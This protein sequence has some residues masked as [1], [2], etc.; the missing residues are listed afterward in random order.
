[1]QILIKPII[2]KL[3]AIHCVS[4]YSIEEHA[5]FID[6]IRHWQDLFID[7]QTL[8]LG[9]EKVDRCL[10]FISRLPAYFSP[11]PQLGAFLDIIVSTSIDSSLPQ[12]IWD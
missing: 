9:L 12:L 1:M 3:S 10:Y 11:D 5:L 8:R 2:R 6:F 7:R 4:I